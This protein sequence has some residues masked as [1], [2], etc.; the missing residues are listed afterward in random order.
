[1]ISKNIGRHW[2]PFATRKKQEYCCWSKWERAFH[3]GQ[4]TDDCRS[5]RPLEVILVTQEERL[6]ILRCTHSLKDQPVRSL[7]DLAPEDQSKVRDAITEL[8]ERQ[9]NGET[10][11]KIRDFRVVW[12]RPHVEWLSMSAPPRVRQQVKIIH[13]R[14]LL[15]SL[16]LLFLAKQSCWSTATVYL[17]S[18]MILSTWLKE[19]LL[20]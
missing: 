7:C 17:G 3:L 18:V 2:A 9:N 15:S 13:P 16:T 19:R 11:L 14:Q 20:F 4:R 12:E 5:P 10:D 6:T 1:M 8:R